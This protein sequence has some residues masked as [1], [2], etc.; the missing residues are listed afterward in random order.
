[1]IM[2]KKKCRSKVS[3]SSIDKLNLIGHMIISRTKQLGE[4]IIKYQ[5]Q[6]VVHEIRNT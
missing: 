6:L 1:M 3:L 2:D 5:K 4:T